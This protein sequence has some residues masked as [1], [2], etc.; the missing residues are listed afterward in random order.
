MAP[1]R[2]AVRFHHEHPDASAFRV[3]L[4]GSLAATGKGHLTDTVLVRAF[5][6]RLVDILWKPE[7]TLS[8][9]PT[10][11]RLEALGPGGQI[12][13]VREEYSL[14]GGALRSDADTGDIYPA[15]T[16]GALLQFCDDTGRMPWEFAAHYEDT[17]IQ[18][19][20]TDIWTAMQE[21]VERGLDAEGIIPGGLDLPRKA[22]TMHHRSTSHHSFMQDGGLVAAYAYAVAEENA[23]GGR[24]VTAPTCGSCGVVPAVLY[25]LQDHLQ[26]HSRTVLQALCTAGLTGNIVKTT[27]SISGAA[28]GCQGEIGVACAMAAAAAAQL[29]GGTPHQIEYAAEMG[30]EHHFGLTCDPVR[31]LVQIPCIERNAHAA[32]RAL[33]C[34]GFALLSD[35]VHRISFDDA[36]AVLVETG[37]ALPDLYK[38]TSGGGLARIYEKAIANRNT[39]GHD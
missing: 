28:V 35:G 7:E 15:G 29:L 4:Y 1:S 8:D 31:G 21:S 23:C 3:T 30:L 32:T 20:L 6:P 38:E 27:G 19:F 24:I 33:S 13:D 14:G 18:N 34:A 25:F 37:H 11:F 9:C 10:G 22:K 26:S 2:A 36:V 39:S 12:L 5:A 16:W 17:D